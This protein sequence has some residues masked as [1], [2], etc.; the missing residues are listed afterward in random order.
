MSKVGVTENQLAQA[1][2][3]WEEERREKPDEFFNDTERLEMTAETFGKKLA[4]HLMGILKA[5]S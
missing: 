3:E 1:F 4:L 5:Q 2:T